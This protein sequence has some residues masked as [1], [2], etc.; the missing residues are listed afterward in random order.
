[1]FTS[2]Y[3]MKVS[4]K[5]TNTAYTEKHAETNLSNFSKSILQQTTGSCQPLAEG[6]NVAPQS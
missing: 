2:E 1:M 4:P 5:D 3:V 6:L